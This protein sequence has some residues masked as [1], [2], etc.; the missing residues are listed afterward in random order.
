LLI[1]APNIFGFAE[2]GGA[3]VFLPRLLGVI[4]ILQALFTH[5]ELGAFKV[6][7]MKAHLAVDYV[8]AILLAISPWLFGFVQL[9]GNFWMVHVVVGIAYFVVT[10]LTEREPRR[11]EIRATV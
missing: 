10:L 6:F 2:V 1:F 11:K 9:A 8:A 3:A 4:F 7:P 5:Y